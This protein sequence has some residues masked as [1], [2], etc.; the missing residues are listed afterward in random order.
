MACSVVF[1]LVAFHFANPSLQHKR[2]MFAYENFSQQV[3]CNSLGVARIKRL[4]KSLHKLHILN[5][6]HSMDIS[7]LI[8]Q[9]VMLYAPAMAANMAPV[10]AARY[11][12][13]PWLNKPLDFG[14]RIRG[15]RMFGDNKTV[16]GFVLGII[17]GACIGALESFVVSVGPFS[18]LSFAIAFGAWSG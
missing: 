1:S 4:W 6:G 3:F 5:N 8:S 16:R 10:F 18:S 15:V 12:M 13:I 11:N 14:F 7:Q 2:S 17:A 9:V